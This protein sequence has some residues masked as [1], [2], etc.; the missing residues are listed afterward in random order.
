M[1][2]VPFFNGCKTYSHLDFAGVY[3]CNSAV[4]EY[5]C[6]VL[7]LTFFKPS[8][9][10]NTAASAAK[11]GVSD[12]TTLDPLPSLGCVISPF[13]A[14]MFRAAVPVATASWNL[15]WI[16]W[17]VSSAFDCGGDK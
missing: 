12:V 10:P 9:L 16:V 11:D 1:D 13:I 15:C 14:F 3:E 7:C 2:I 5:D 6:V 4:I 8:C 17:R